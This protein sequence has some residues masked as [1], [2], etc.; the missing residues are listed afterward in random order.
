MAWTGLGPPG[1]TGET[2]QRRKILSTINF[3]PTTIYYPIDSTLAGTKKCLTYSPCDDDEEEARLDVCDDEAH[4]Q[5]HMGR[6]W[7]RGRVGVEWLV[8]VPEIDPGFPQS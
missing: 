5:P 2:G 7:F 1:G 3:C 4:G 8:E 6:Q